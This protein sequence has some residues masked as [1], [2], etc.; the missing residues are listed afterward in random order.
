L[1]TVCYA[2]HT[3]LLLLKDIRQSVRRQSVNLTQVTLLKKNDQV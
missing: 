3:V 1:T 2:Q